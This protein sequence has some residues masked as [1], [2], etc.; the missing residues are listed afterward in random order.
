MITG[1]HVIVY[2][3]AA[4]ADRSFLLELLGTRH[5][6]AGGGWLI[7]ALPPAEIAVHPTDGAPKQELHL[8]CDDIDKTVSDLTAR[9]V[10]FEGGVRDQGWGLWTSIQLPSGGTVGLYQPRHPIAAGTTD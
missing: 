2:S 5:V 3:T 9:G 7:V 4:E 6:D 1:A 8:M 10:T